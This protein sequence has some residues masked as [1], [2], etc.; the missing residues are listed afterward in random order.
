VK[1][2]KGFLFILFAAA[3]WSTTGFF[4]RS[5]FARGMDPLAVGFWRSAAGVL[6]L[7]SYLFARRRALLH[8]SGRDL[9]FFALFGFTSITLFSYFYL[10][11]IHLIT[12]AGAAVLLY[13][14]PAFAVVMAAAF[15]KEPLTIRKGFCVLLA[16]GGAFLV[17]EGYQAAAFRFNLPG[18][19]TGLAAALTYAGYSIF[20]RKAALARYHHWT[21]VFYSLLFGTLFL[22]ALAVPRGLAV[23]MNLPAAASLLLFGLLTTVLAY[24]LYNRGL[25]EVEAG[26]AGIVAA[27]EVVLAVLW[28]VFVFQESL[29]LWQGVGIVL[30]LAATLLIQMS[31][32]TCNSPAPGNPS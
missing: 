6:L 17:V 26:R 25:Q 31:P 4:S 14:A 24:G 16:L 2:S 13:T 5:L 10:T 32:G 9:V 21:T 20:G 30:V 23:P 22:G 29:T 8:V 28:G 3:L 12:L 19:L 18:I 1:F 15:L 11:T 27:S 7:F